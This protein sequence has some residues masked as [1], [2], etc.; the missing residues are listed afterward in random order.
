MP[1]GIRITKNDEHSD[2]DIFLSKIFNI[3]I[4]FDEFIKLLLTSRENRNQI[5]IR[6]VIKNLKIMYDFRYVIASVI[7]FGSI[8]YLTII[9]KGKFDDVV[10]KT[11]HN[12]SSELFFSFLDEYLKRSFKK[13]QNTYYSVKVEPIMIKNMFTL[14]CVID[15]RLV[16]FIIAFFK[17]YRVIPKLFR[18]LRRSE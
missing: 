13:V 4:D 2:V 16:Y 17:N 14:E 5:T 6:S 3:R 10:L 9:M 12:I 18:L 8:R 11:Y 7:S 15:I 1:I